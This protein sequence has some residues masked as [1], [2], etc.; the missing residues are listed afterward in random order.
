MRD[1]QGPWLLPPIADRL[2]EVEHE[3]ESARPVA[4]TAAL[5]VGELPELLGRS[6]PVHWLV[7]TV[8]P[9]EAR[10]IG[11]L[12][13]N[14]LVIEAD[15]GRVEILTSGRNEDLNAALAGVGATLQGPDRYRDRWGMSTPERFFQDVGLEPDLASV[16]AVAADLYEQATGLSIE[17]VV[18][19][20]PFAFAAILEVT[21]PLTVGQHRL[22]SANVAE[23]LLI[24]QYVEYA[25]D[26]AGRVLLL[27]TLVSAAFDV[28]TRSEL[29]GPAR[30][31]NHRSL[32]RTGS[33]R[34]VVK[35]GGAATELIDLSGLDSR[36]PA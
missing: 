16:G 7:L 18:T 19:V 31:R 30:S 32:G 33:A 34:P 23:F 26:E 27:G 1:V 5:A 21:G 4:Q 6:G 29:P 2:E 8:T 22:G 28:L 14:Y 3:L 25:D 9:A 35:P 13:G 11:G 20:D 17:G 15:A 10:G 36:F 12:V 24:D